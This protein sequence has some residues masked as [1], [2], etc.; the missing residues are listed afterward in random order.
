MNKIFYL[1]MGLLFIIILYILNDACKNNEPFTAN[2]EKQL[3]NNDNINAQTAN[4]TSL[5]TPTANINKLIINDFKYLQLKQGNNI[6]NSFYIGATTDT[7][8]TVATLPGTSSTIQ[9]NN[10]NVSVQ[11]VKLV[12]KNNLVCVNGSDNYIYCNVAPN[13]WVNAPNGNFFITKSNANDFTIRTNT[14]T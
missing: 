12:N 7:D 4:I 8:G 3:I 6:I 13:N 10:M 9:D 11:N 14:C 2:D 1:F 5:T